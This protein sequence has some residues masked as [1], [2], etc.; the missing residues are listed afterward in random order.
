M[1]LADEFSEVS[2]MS[3]DRDVNVVWDQVAKDLRT[4]GV[5]TVDLS[6]T[7]EDLH[8][9]SFATARIA[10]DA[11]QESPDCIVWIP[12]DADSAH[13][14]G[15]HS[16][17]GANSLSRYNAHREGFVVSDNDTLEME[18]VPAFRHSM[19]DLSKSLHTIANHTLEA[20]ERQL[21]IHPGW[22]QEN[23]GPTITSSQFHVKRYVVPVEFDDDHDEPA[24]SSTSGDDKE[25]SSEPRILLPMHTDP[26]LISVVLHDAKGRNPSARGLQYYCSD[27]RRWIPVPFHGH[28]VAVLFVGSVL[29]YMTGNTI[30]PS[31]KHRVIH[32]QH[33]EKDDS[34]SLEEAR[35]RVAATLFVRPQLPATLQVPPSCQLLEIAARKKPAVTFSTW[36]ARVSKNYSK[37]TKNK[38]TIDR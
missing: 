21:D 11:V 16:A 10:L 18:T 26:S 22:F 24:A 29:S 32:D 17:G 2:G 33:Q 14:T 12:V 8:G 23:L 35:R 9:R 19:T 6:Q 7:A 34:S 30:F 37:K 13:A 15:F 20:I 5:A 36:I 3:S 27:E 25:H 1:N 31:I 28:G 4:T 38:K